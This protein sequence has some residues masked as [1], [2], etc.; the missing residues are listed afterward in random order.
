MLEGVIDELIWIKVFLHAL[1]A[2]FETAG[3]KVYSHAAHPLSLRGL[4]N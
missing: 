1:Q 4:Y 3:C 2:V